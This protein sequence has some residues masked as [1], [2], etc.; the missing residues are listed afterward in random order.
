MVGVNVTK[1]TIFPKFTYEFNMTSI[2]ISVEFCKELDKNCKEKRGG[3]G[4]G[5]IFF[6]IGARQKATVVVW[7]MCYCHREQGP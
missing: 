6:P 3:E 2:K 1:R 4:R 5:G 7:T